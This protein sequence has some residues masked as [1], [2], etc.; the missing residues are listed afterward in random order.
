MTW[1]AYVTID[2]T[3]PD[4]DQPGATISVGDMKHW[5]LKEAA[6]QEVFKRVPNDT[7]ITGA[8]DAAIVLAKAIGRKV[9][10]TLTGH[11]NDGLKKP[12]WT[13]DFIRVEVSDLG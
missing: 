7:Q 2:P 1:Q 13:N 10:A 5:L 8:I 4:A 11:H 3:L 9:S 6:I 12:G